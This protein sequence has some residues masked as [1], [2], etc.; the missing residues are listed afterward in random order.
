VWA[1]AA[2]QLIDEARGLPVEELGR[3]ARAM[4][5]RLDPIGARERYERQYEARSWRMW[6]DEDGARHARID[7]DHEMGAWVEAI[8]DAALRPRRGGPRF[9]TDEQRAEAALLEQDSRTNDQ[10]AYD[11]MTDLLRAGA[12]ARS[13]DV[14][15]ARQP[16]VRMVVFKDAVGRR[17][18]FG[19]LLGIGHIEDGGEAVPGPVL[20][21]SLCD[22]GAVEVTVD[23]CGNPLD[24]GREQ[25]LFTAKQRI[26]LAVRDGGCIWPGCDRP[27]SYCE[28]HHIDGW[29]GGGRTDTERGALLCRFHHLLLHNHGW[30]ITRESRGAF[31]LHP[32][33]GRDRDG[34]APGGGG[35]D[36][37]GREP[38]GQGRDGKEP[39]RRGQHDDGAIVLRSRSPLRWAFDPPPDR[40]G[41]RAA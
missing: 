31:R 16:G 37:D 41:W 25:R 6:T 30:R 10:L 5:D 21:R 34:G 2:E 11:L 17:D 1:V 33:A 28:A 3:R 15:G 40:A 27:P 20:D 38:P 8:R 35:R 14:F 36:R 18:A 26:A 39:D 12:L 9:L 29:A 7:F 23:S 24:V 4:R 22:A 19:R 32:P 13:E